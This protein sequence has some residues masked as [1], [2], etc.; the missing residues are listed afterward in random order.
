[1]DT[2]MTNA[3]DPLDWLAAERHQPGGSRVAFRQQL[4]DCNALLVDIG[5]E[6]ADQ[7]LPITNAFLEADAHRANEWVP[8]GRHL[9]AR[10]RDL[11]EACYLILATQ[12]PVASD[13]RRVVAT[14][15]CVGDLERSVN[16]LEHIAG[17]LAWVHPPSFPDEL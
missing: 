16:L 1:M 3:R 8:L 10:C 7:V 5:Q 11:E 12:S 17:S 14:L 13:L 6:V 9:S 15:R 2:H 4:E